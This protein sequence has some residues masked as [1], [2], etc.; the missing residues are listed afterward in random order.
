MP[1]AA[2]VGV[3]GDV[4][5]VPHRV[6]AGADR[7]SPTSSPV[8]VA[9]QA[10]ARGLGQLEHEHGQRPRRGERAPL[11]RDDLRQVRVGQAP[12]AQIGGGRV[13]HGGLFACGRRS[14]RRGA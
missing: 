1:C 2:A 8:A 12:E 3:D 13:G 4:H 6:V 14:P 5:D 10:D 9:R 11:D 7:G